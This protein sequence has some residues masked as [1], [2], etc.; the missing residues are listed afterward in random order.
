MGERPN[1]LFIISDQHNPKYLGHAGHPVVKTP[2]LDRLAAEGVRFTTAI[3]QNPICTPSRM[4]FFSGQYCHNHGYYGLNGPNPNGL[5]TVLGHFR[6]GGYRTGAIGKVH[7]PEYWIEDDCEVFKEA[8][9]EF[10]VGGAPQYTA[11]LRSR[12]LVVDRD[13]M[14]LPEHPDGPQALDGRVS[15]LSYEDAVEAVDFAPTLCALAGLDPLQTADGRDISHL[16]RGEP[17]DVHRI[18]VT[19]FAWSKSVRKGTYRYVYYP[20]E[21]FAGDYPDGFGELYDL[22]RDPWE[23]DNLWFQAEY[24]PVVRELQSE[25]F[26]WLVTTTRPKTVLGAPLVGGDQAI[27]RFNRSINRDGKLHPDQLRRAIEQGRLFYL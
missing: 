7:C 13:D 12:G 1:I 19:E 5:P 14:H 24:A 4:S 6:C 21:M 17:G 11:Y 16:L 18:G 27:V 10:S 20:R 26:D 8:C 2:N 15:R 9:A 22:E 25:L 23:M 3:T